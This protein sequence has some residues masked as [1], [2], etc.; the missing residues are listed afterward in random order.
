MPGQRTL[1]GELPNSL[2]EQFQQIKLLVCDV[3]G[4]FSDGRIYLG[5]DGEELKAFHT[6]DGYGVKA[7]IQSGVEVAV[8]T[9]RRSELV[10]NRMT[11]LGVKHIIQGEE[12]KGVALQ[13]LQDKLGINV[14]QTAAIGDDCP[15]LGMFDNALLGIAVKDAHPRVINHAAYVTQN[16]GGYGAV[17]E[18]CDIILESKNLLKTIES[19]SV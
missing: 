3:D 14:V 7:L 5:N 15:D 6:R 9:G 1:Y 18:V 16:N 19:A 13:H 4:V 2:F 11:A 10:H 8:I 17:R 12:H